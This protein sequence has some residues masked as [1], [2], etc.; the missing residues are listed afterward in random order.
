MNNRDGF[1]S[2]SIILDI[3]FFF[4]FFVEQGDS[5]CVDKRLNECSMHM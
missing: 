5:I 2:Y 3:F 4:F 1:V